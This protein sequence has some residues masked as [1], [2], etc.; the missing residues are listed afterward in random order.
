MDPAER[1]AADRSAQREWRVAQVNLGIAAFWLV[2]ALL[3]WFADDATWEPQLF[4]VLGIGLLVAALSNL[5]QQQRNRRRRQ[6]R[7]NP[8]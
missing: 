2:L 1:A 7:E 8:G 4:T 6:E 3:W 5:R